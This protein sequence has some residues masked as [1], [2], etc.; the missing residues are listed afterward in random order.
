MTTTLQQLPT[1][2]SERELEPEYPIH[3]GYLYVADGKVIRAMESLTAEEFKQK[4]G[5][6]ILKNCDISARDLWSATI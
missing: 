6:E 2:P 3:A 4:A 5:I 1:V